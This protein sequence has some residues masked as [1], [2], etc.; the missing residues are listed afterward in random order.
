MR[1]G[2]TQGPLSNAKIFICHHCQLNIHSCFPSASESSMRFPLSSG[3]KESWKLSTQ[4][5]NSFKNRPGL[6][7]LKCNFL[8]PS[9]LA[10]SLPSHFINCMQPWTVLALLGSAGTVTACLEIPFQAPRT[11]AVLLKELL[12]MT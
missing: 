12:F 5:K 2:F 7:N 8:F 4:G 9:S 11:S 6:S 3:T 10:N 1:M